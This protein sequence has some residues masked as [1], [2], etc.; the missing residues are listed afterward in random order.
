[1]CNVG[2][3]DTIQEVLLIFATFSTTLQT[4]RLAVTSPGSCLAGY[5]SKP[6]RLSVCSVT[7]LL[8][9]PFP[10]PSPLPPGP[11]PHLASLLPSKMSPQALS[12]WLS[13]CQMT[14]PGLILTLKLLRDQSQL[15]VP[16]RVNIRGLSQLPC[17]LVRSVQQLSQGSSTAAALPPPPCVPL[18]RC[19]HQ[20][21]LPSQDIPLIV[22]LLAD[23]VLHELPAG[24]KIVH[25]SAVTAAAVVTAQETEQHE[26]YAEC[27]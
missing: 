5:C 16:Y 6:F 14:P 24:K 19:A 1:M 8:Q 3:Q 25:A 23:T 13:R 27:V 26:Q 15:L 9:P 2:Q 7:C 4:V 12:I 18:H 22:N 17:L 11:C 10:F 20:T 21:C